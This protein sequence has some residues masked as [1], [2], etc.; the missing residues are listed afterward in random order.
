MTKHLLNLLS[1][2]LR[3]SWPLKRNNVG[4]LVDPTQIPIED[5]WTVYGNTTGVQCGLTTTF[6]GYSTGTLTYPNYTPTYTP[7]W[8]SGGI[9]QGQTT[10]NFP[11]PA[12]EYTNILTTA[13]D[14]YKTR[15]EIGTLMVL[16][17]ID[18][19]QFRNMWELSKS[20]DKEVINLLRI[21]ISEIQVLTAYENPTKSKEIG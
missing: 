13:Y 3:E 17:K 7:V 4:G 15:E 18:P 2:T 20:E 8:S 9:W 6:S 14:R 10:I 12:V 5:T 16:G 1:K 11:D 19:E 21:L